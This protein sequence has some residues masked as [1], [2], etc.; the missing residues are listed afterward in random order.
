MEPEKKALT[1][2]QQKNLLPDISRAVIEGKPVKQLLN[3]GVA[4]SSIEGGLA[5]KILQA[6]TMLHIGGNLLPHEP[7]TIAQMLLN[8]Y[9]TASMDDFSIMLQRG[10]M[11]RYGKVFGFDVSIVFSWMASYM[12][13][14]AEEKE[15]Q[16][17]KER[18]KL[19]E[20]VEPE[21]GQ[22]SPETE[23]LVREF[24][25][26]LSGGQKKVPA[27]SMKEIREEGQERPKER[28]ASSYIPNP[29]YAIMHQKKMQWMK[30]TFHPI[31]REQY[32]GALSFDE[33]LRMD[34]NL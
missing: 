1:L 12:G 15:K 3:E 31:T 9:P 17:A 6:S 13:E 25:E 19:S 8:E 10:I 14:W 2:T 30:E 26:M 23:K 21:P 18:N 22:W 4:Q 20:S 27:M 11:G 5:A 7:I 16:L 32:E 28:R 33:W 34:G 29:E 24:Q